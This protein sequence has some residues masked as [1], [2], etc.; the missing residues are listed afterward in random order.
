MCGDG[1][2]DCGVSLSQL[3]NKNMIFFIVSYAFL[4]KQTETL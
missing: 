1:A 3:Y 2:N 4:Q